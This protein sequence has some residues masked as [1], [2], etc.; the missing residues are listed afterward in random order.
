MIA[1]LAATATFALASGAALATQIVIY[2]AS[3][4]VNSALVRARMEGGLSTT[5]MGDASIGFSL[6]MTVSDSEL[7]LIFEAVR[8]VA[9]A[10]Q[11]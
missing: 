9:E 8:K 7:D 4:C 3:D 11:R 6:P 1:R 2:N 5:S 10:I